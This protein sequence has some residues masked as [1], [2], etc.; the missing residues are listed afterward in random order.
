MRDGRCHPIWTVW[1]PLLSVHSLT[2]S[3]VVPGENHV[4]NTYFTWCEGSEGSVKATSYHYFSFSKHYWGRKKGFLWVAWNWAINL[5]FVHPEKAAKRNF[6]HPVSR[7]PLIFLGP[8]VQKVAGT[9]QIGLW[10][11][12]F[13]WLMVQEILD[14]SSILF[15]FSVSKIHIL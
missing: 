3:F 1:L 4:A 5:R 8:V 11:S 12:K 6:F 13:A 9:E 15:L 7:N 14:N 2:H 10:H